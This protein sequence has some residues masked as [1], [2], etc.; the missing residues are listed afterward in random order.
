LLGALTACTSVQLPA[1]PVPL[2]P[3]AF[4]TG[5]TRGTGTLRPLVG[6]SA[7]ISVAS[8]GTPQPGGLRLVQRI[9]EG[10]KPER[11]RTWVMQRLGPGRYTGTL[12]DAEGPVA[13]EVTGPRAT[14]SY[15]TPSGIRI[16]QQ[17][18]LQPGGR[19]LLNRL[20]ATRF[21]LRLAVL[22]EVIV[23]PQPLAK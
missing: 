16:R 17:L 18:A 7:P 14:I 4:F 6:R 21:G 12:T 11:T 15:R 2:D 10:D 8:Q 20:E 22:D 3:I 1:G 5:E 19:T 23:R 9:T 13:I